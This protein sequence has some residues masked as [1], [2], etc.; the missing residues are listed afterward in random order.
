MT[1]SGRFQSAVDSLGRAR[2]LA[3][4]LLAGS[5]LSAQEYSFRSYGNAEVPTNLA[6][7]EIYQGHVGVI[8][9]STHNGASHFYGER[10]EACPPAQRSPASWSGPFG[11]GRGGSL[12]VGGASGLFR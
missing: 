12:C 4:L 1:D 9:V 7:H 8:W 5:A 2:V 11:A 10:S 6:E 3:F